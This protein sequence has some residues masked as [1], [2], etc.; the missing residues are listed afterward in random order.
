[1]PLTNTS[2]KG[3]HN[4][5]YA[6][7]WWYTWIRHSNIIQI[8]KKNQLNKFF[9]KKVAIVCF[10]HRYLGWRC[11]PT[12]CGFSGPLIIGLN[13]ADE[14]LSFTK[15][16]DRTLSLFIKIDNRGTRI[17]EKTNCNLCTVIPESHL[18]SLLKGQHLQK[19]FICESWLRHRRRYS[20][21]KNKL[22]SFNLVAVCNLVSLEVN[23]N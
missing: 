5:R 13:R 11:H 6:R 17:S 3:Q 16:W 18:I 15:F 9:K 1:M 4:T 8:L 7:G 20:S 21:L 23:S 12:F 14:L 2:N 22:E 10:G 19:A